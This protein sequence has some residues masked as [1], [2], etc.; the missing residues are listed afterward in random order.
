MNQHPC[1]RC[2]AL[3]L[4]AHDASSDHAA[5]TCPAC[6][7]R[8]SYDALPPTR[9]RL[10]SG[11]GTMLLAALGV[12]LS[13]SGCE[14]GPFRAINQET[15]YGGPPI[16]ELRPSDQADAGQPDLGADATADETTDVSQEAVPAYG[17][18]PMEEDTPLPTPDDE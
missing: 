9:A 5:L 18:P 13:V 15:I 16:E 3:V 14:R 2:A 1:P 11:R 8:F 4:T 10:G 17:A 12:S 6:G 7:E